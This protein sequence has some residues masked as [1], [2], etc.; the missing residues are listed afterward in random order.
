MHY[1]NYAFYYRRAEIVHKTVSDGYKTL[2]HHLASLIMYLEWF[3]I[4]L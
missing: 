2:L 4:S 1:E 3:F